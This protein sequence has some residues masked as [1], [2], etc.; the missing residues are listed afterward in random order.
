MKAKE[1]V[2]LRV[3]NDM[4]DGMSDEDRRTI[5]LLSQKEDTSRLEEAIARQDEKLG[6]LV[7]RTS[8]SRSFVS[9]VGANVVTNT[10]FLLLAKLL[11]RGL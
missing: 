6:E 1:M 9:D 7:R 5:L 8:W 4:L 11:K 2:R 10:M 3:L